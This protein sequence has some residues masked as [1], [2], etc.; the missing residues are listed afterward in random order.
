[1]PKLSLPKLSLPK[2][3]LPKLSLPKLSLPKL[4][5]PKLSLPKLSLPK[6]SLPKLS[7][8]KL[9]LPKLSLPKLSLPEA[10]AAQALAAQALA[11]QA[12]ECA[13]SRCPSSRC[14]KLSLPKLSL[15]EALAAQALA[16][17]LSR[18][19]KLS[20]PKLSLPKLSLPKLSTRL[21]TP[22]AL[23]LPL[24]GAK[25]Q[26]NPLPLRVLIRRRQRRAAPCDD[27]G[28]KIAFGAAGG[29]NLVPAD[30]AGLPNDREMRKHGIDA[31]AAFAERQPQD[32]D[33]RR[34]AAA[35]ARHAHGENGT[36]RP[37]RM[38][39]K[40]TRPH[41]PGRAPHV[42]STLSRRAAARKAGAHRRRARLP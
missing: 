20:L 12:L 11:A 42:G 7:L 34:C 30:S 37:R 33:P 31:S 32:L 19:P 14:P 25:Q 3:S 8:P 27:G 10:L 6:L 24:R 4:S 26:R 5:L 39:D 22:F 29:R 38:P 21:G 40:T 9:S 18:C 13:S 35:V 16:A 36:S 41:R 17:Q 23:L 2:L 28:D 15:P 1:M